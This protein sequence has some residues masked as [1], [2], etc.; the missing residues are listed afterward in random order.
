MSFVPKLPDQGINQSKQFHVLSVLILLGAGVLFLATCFFVFN[1]A[2]SKVVN[3]IPQEK[4]ESIQK[5]ISSKIP[6]PFSTSNKPI[7]LLELFSDIK[8]ES[9]IVSPVSVSILCSDEINAIALPDFRIFVFD[10]LI[11]KLSY[12]N[13][14][15]MVLGHEMGHFSHRHHLKQMGGAVLSGVL[16]AFLGSAGNHFTKAISTGNQLTQLKYS[17]KQEV[18]SDN[19]GLDILNTLYGHVNGADGFFQVIQNI[20]QSHDSNNQKDELNMIEFFQ[21]HPGPKNRIELLRKQ[22]I[23]KGYELDGELVPLPNGI[24]NACKME[25]PQKPLP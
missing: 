20:D 15:A 11:Q 7:E 18:Q 9:N 10:G 8:S 21:T 4:F 5:S 14:L 1:F 2:V 16:S 3:R 24:K 19:V 22:S 6:L 23:K 25:R 17:R 13:E 12:E